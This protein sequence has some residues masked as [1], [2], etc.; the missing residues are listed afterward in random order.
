MEASSWSNFKTLVSDKTL[1]IQYSENARGYN[2]YAPEAS[3]FMWHIWVPK[4]GGADVADFETNFK[5]TA[6]APMMINGVPMSA[7]SVGET[8]IFDALAIRDTAAHNS[9]A[10][11]NTGYRVKTIIVSNGL[12][13]IVTMQCQGSRDG[14]NW[15]NIG[16]TW[17]VA[18][19]ASIYQ[20]SD[21]YFPFMRSV[22]TCAVAPASGALSMWL[23]KVGV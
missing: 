6:N 11:S 22:A 9:T 15:L 17:D 3:V 10:S 2:L 16:E 1:L 12:N 13:Q 14:T 23:E 8:A 20:S 18:A 5:P 21:T 4:D 7:P 19:G